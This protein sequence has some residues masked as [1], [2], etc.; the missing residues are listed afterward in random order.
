MTR[1]SNFLEQNMQKVI[2]KKDCAFWK[3]SSETTKTAQQWVKQTGHSESSQHCI[4]SNRRRASEKV[5]SEDSS[6]L[7][8]ETTTFISTKDHRR[9]ERLHS[10]HNGVSLV[11]P[12]LH[13]LRYDRLRA[14]VFI[15]GV[16]FVVFVWLFVVFSCSLPREF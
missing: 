6:T 9:A 1:G 10:F 11:S 8:I 12:S 5:R 4:V 7:D 2:H 13:F 14:W 16:W 3:Q 15:F